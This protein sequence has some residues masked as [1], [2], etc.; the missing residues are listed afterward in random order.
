M[1]DG[2]GS[3]KVGR[4]GAIALKLL[5]SF[6]VLAAFAAV[7]DGQTVARLVREIHPGYVVALLLLSVVRIGIA[8]VR[9]RLLIDPRAPLGLGELSRQ[10]FIG[11]YFSTLLPTSIG[12][13]AVRVLLLGRSSLSKS[14]AAVYVL[15]ERL[16]GIPVLIGMTFIG[17]LIF[18]VVDEIRLA[19]MGLA[20]LAVF[21]AAMG[22]VGGRR[23]RGMSSRDTALGRAAGAATELLDRPLQLGLGLLATIVFQLAAVALS[24]ITALAFDIELSFAACLA[25]VPVVWLITLLPVSIGGVGVRE[26]SFALLLGTVGIAL[27]E[28]LLISL[29]TYAA[30]LFCAAIGGLILVRDDTVRTLLGK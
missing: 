4:P 20:L 8:A 18:P 9:L 7:I 10:H 21:A 12:G 24:Y 27:E 23:L 17:T 19:V 25:L 22:I 29:G 2:N 11:A 16:L 14:E 15:M 5:V 13:D 1:A 26:A 30:M 28:S 3:R 6:G